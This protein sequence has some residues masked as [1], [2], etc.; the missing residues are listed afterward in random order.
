LRVFFNA[1]NLCFVSAH[2]GF[3]PR[4]GYTGTSF[5]NFPQARTFTFGLTLNM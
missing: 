5:V 2:D 1:D 3:D 4:A